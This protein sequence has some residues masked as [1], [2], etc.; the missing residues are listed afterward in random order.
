MH[1]D[2]KPANILIRFGLLIQAVLTDMGLAVDTSLPSHVAGDAVVSNLTAHVCSTG[3]TAPEL[4]AV[5]KDESAEYGPSVDVWS[6][7]VVAFEV[8]TLR[9]FISR[10]SNED[11]MWIIGCRLGNV[12]KIYEARVSRYISSTCEIRPCIPLYTK[13]V[14]EQWQSL[15]ALCLTWTL[16]EKGHGRPSRGINE[17]MYACGPRLRNGS[18]G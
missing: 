5:R 7:T 9:N 15:L 3:Y 11:E 10:R 18:P 2:I 14:E 17:G 12:P 4:L 13:L 1:R 8:F 16:G 6:A